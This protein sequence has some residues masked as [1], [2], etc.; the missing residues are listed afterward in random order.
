MRHQPLW[1]L[2]VHGS[3]LVPPCASSV[4]DLPPAGPHT[5]SHSMCPEPGR[6]HSAPCPWG[7]ACHPCVTAAFLLQAALFLLRGW[8]AFAGLSPGHGHG[9]RLPLGWPL[10]PWTRGLGGQEQRP[11]VPSRCPVGGPGEPPQAENP[12]WVSRTQH[13][14]RTR[15][16]VR[17]ACRRESAAGGR[18][19][20]SS[21]LAPGRLGVSIPE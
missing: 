20:S 15:P 1:P 7:H 12:G 6:F 18:Q 9:V 13:D 2:R 5:G 11:W 14:S 3:P 10:S 16:A 8:T 17:A 21:C 4:S 19:G